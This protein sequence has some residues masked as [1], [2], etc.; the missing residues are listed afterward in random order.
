MD[1]CN[2]ILS[3]CKPNSIL[4]SKIFTASPSSYLLFI[5]FLQCHWRLSTIWLFHLEDCRDDVSAFTVTQSYPNI[6][7]TSGFSKREHHL[8]FILK[9]DNTLLLRFMICG[10]SPIRLPQSRIPDEP[11]FGCTSIFCSLADEQGREHS[12][13]ISNLRFHFSM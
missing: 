3:T 11:I 8:S 7:F 6:L 2:I 1:V 10:I 5:E 4:S 13:Y 12:P 9:S